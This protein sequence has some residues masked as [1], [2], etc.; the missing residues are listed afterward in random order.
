MIWSTKQRFSILAFSI[1]IWQIGL[2]YWVLVPVVLVGMRYFYW[3]INLAGPWM[4]YRVGVGHQYSVSRRGRRYSDINRDFGGSG[5][6]RFIMAHIIWKD[7]LLNRGF[8]IPFGRKTM[9]RYCGFRDCW[10]G[11]VQSR[12]T[13]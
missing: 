6:C 1:I 13:Y 4:R 5:L 8:Y 3:I 7:W 12:I 2:W 11:R 10:E 9:R